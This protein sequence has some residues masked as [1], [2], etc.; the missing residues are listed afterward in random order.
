M[1][2]DRPTR[3]GD[4]RP[5]AVDPTGEAA[6]GTERPGAGPPVRPGPQGPEGARVRTIDQGDG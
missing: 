1:R 5:Q 3:S 2:R 4:R 6:A